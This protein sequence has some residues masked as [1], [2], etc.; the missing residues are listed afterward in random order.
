MNK[1]YIFLFSVL[2]ILFF[3]IPFVKKNVIIAFNAI[4]ETFLNLKKNINDE[5]NAISN[6][7]KLIKELEEKNKKLSFELSRLNAIFYTCKD[8]KKFKFIRKPGL[9]FTQA[10][11]YVK[12]PDF[13][14]V[15]VTFDKPVPH[16]IGLV[17]N[18]FAAG[19][20]V[21]RVGNY[22]V[23]LLNS[24][25]KTSYAVYI[26]KNEIP[27][28]FYGKEN[29]IKYIPK[30]KP[31]KVGDL[32]ITSGLDNIFYKGALVGKITEI[33]EKKL[34]QEAKIKLFY[35]TLNPTYF[36]AVTNKALIAPDTNATDTNTT[37]ENLTKPTK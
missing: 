27:G 36:Y 1:R 3:Q 34:Y 6:N 17:Y 10:V 37:E 28:I 35:D 23:A 15:Y 24:N 7:K 31:I 26:G 8:L 20:I 22:G 25:P 14:S 12:L 11:S 18:N 5:L 29:V 32:V 4:K 9:E 2:L 19:M 13:T 21:K 33:K 30:F 16:P